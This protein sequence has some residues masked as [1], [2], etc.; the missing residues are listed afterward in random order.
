MKQNAVSPFDAHADYVKTLCIARCGRSEDLRI[1]DLEKIFPE[2]SP[3]T[4]HN[5]VGKRK[6]MVAGRSG[7]LLLFTWKEITLYGIVL[8]KW[9]NGN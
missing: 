6:L 8:G 5:D 9:K 7:K 3:K 1:S 4:M 2:R